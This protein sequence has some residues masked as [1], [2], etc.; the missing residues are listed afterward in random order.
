MTSMFSVAENFNQDIG[1]WDVS[2]VTNIS[3]MFDGAKNFNQDIGV[4]VVNL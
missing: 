2:N 3:E 1:D 4:K